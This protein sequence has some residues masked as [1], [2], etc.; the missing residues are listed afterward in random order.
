MSLVVISF[1]DS[2]RATHLIMATTTLVTLLRLTE[3]SKNLDSDSLWLTYSSGRYILAAHYRHMFVEPKRFPELFLDGEKHSQVALRL[4]EY[5]CDH[6]PHPIPYR[7]CQTPK[8]HSHYVGTSRVSTRPFHSLLSRG[9]RT[10]NSFLRKRREK[11]HRYG[12]TLSIP[13]TSRPSGYLFSSA[14]DACALG[15]LLLPH[16][17][18]RSSS[19][20]ELATFIRRNGSNIA[21]LPNKT[22]KAIRAM[23]EYLDRSDEEGPMA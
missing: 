12:V 14:H 16:I 21:F 6:V 5:L 19:S 7:K 13:D 15:M 9:R 10:G 22:R 4:L 20:S 2:D 23:H 18:G 11:K 1:L 8:T 17:L 3:D